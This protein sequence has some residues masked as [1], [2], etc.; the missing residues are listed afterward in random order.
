[1]TFK[2]SIDQISV[3]EFQ[4]YNLIT[5]NILK[6]VLILILDSMS[7]LPYYNATQI[8]CPSRVIL[9]FPINDKL[10]E[11]IGRSAEGAVSME[12]SPAMQMGD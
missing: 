4:P 5:Q 7:M 1:M 6:M 3:D 2:V 9:I 10:T 11:K 8:H 12:Q